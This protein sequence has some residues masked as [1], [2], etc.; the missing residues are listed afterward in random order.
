M[1]VRG[2]RFG[3]KPREARGQANEGNVGP[4]QPSPHRHSGHHRPKLI[5]AKALVLQLFLE[6]RCPFLYCRGKHAYSTRTTLSNHGK[7]SPSPSFLG[8]LYYPPLFS[9][10]SNSRWKTPFTC[11]SSTADLG[12]ADEELQWKRLELMVHLIDTE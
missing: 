10:Q 11:C 12:V 2:I 7:F 1:P 8:K 4:N 5:N 3:P 9:R 6:A